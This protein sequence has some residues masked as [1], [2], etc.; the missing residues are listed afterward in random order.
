MPEQ[1]KKARKKP[2]VIEYREVEP[3]QKVVNIETGE[4]IILKGEPVFGE[5]ILT[6]EGTLLAICG[7]DYVIRGIEGEL[8]PIKKEIF[9]KTYD[10]VE[11]ELIE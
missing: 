3:K 8:Y 11:G 5:E 6:R 7:V 10:A 4:Q 2:V 1:W 9:D